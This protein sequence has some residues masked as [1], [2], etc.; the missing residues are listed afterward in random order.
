[1][2]NQLPLSGQ[3]MQFII[4]LSVN[5]TFFSEQILTIFLIVI[6]KEFQ[7]AFT[8]MK[9]I[10]SLMN[11]LSP[12]ALEVS[13]SSAAGDNKFINMMTFQF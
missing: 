6:L 7:N 2:Q 3:I 4:Y 12:A 11:L 9:K 10:I 1:M 5:F 8:E 13:T